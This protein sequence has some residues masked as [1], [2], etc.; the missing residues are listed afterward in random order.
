MERVEI[1]SI[2]RKARCTEIEW[3]FKSKR[4]KTNLYENSNK[5]LSISSETKELGKDFV[6]E[7]F[8]ALSKE[9]VE[10]SFAKKYPKKEKPKSDKDEKAILDSEWQKVL[11]ANQKEDLYLTALK[12]AHII[13]KKKRN[14]IQ[15]W[16]KE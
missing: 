7:L 16:R 6:T 15:V 1:I 5:M 12:K 3:K 11:N 2:N 14:T 13:D 8:I 9:L 10:Y 4:G